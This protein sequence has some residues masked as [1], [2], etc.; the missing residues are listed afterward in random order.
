MGESWRGEEEGG[1]W[2]SG[3]VVG[4]KESR[5][6][7][8][9]VQAQGSPNRDAESTRKGK[10][11]QEEEEIGDA[12]ALRRARM[13]SYS[14]HLWGEERE[15]ELGGE[16]GSR[17]LGSRGHKR[18]M[19]RESYCSLPPAGCGAGVCVRVCK[20]A[21]LRERVRHWSILGAF[22][23]RAGSSCQARLGGGKGRK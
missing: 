21:D 11:K 6:G 9:Q 15:E 12:K 23:C 14:L 22:G 10:R 16:R 3:L 13:A 4:D 7:K 5:K 17:E 2:V 18:P 20:T 8:A 1:G 19:Q